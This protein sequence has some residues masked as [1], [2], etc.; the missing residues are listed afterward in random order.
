[1]LNKTQVKFL[2]QLTDLRDQER[3]GDPAVEE[4]KLSLDAFLEEY[5]IPYPRREYGNRWQFA[6]YTVNCDAL[7]YIGSLEERKIPRF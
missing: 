2:R 3:I 4:R 5:D 1:M 7:T 6:G